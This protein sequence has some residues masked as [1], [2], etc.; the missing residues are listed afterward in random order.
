MSSELKQGSSCD[1]S[2]LFLHDTPLI[3]TRSPGEF[4]KGSFPHA[5]NLPL[6]LDDERAKVG[7]CYKQ[8]GQ[9]AAI[10]L[11]HKLVCGEIKQQRVERWLEFA[12][13][14]PQGYLFCW[15]G[16]LRSQISLEW[17]QEAGV[18]YPRIP[19][20]Y[21]AL[22]RFLIDQ[23][24]AIIQKRPLIL[25]AGRTGSG[26]THVLNSLPTSIDLEGLAHHRGSS[27]GKRPYGQPSQISFENQLAIALLKKTAASS[28]PL[29][30]EDESS[31]IGRCSL[32][33][34]LYKQMKQSP[35]ILLEVPLEDRVNTIQ[36]DYIVELCNEYQQVHQEHG[37]DLF[38]SMLRNGL[39][40]IAKRLGGQSTQ[41]I[42]QILEEALA[43]QLSHGETAM[44]KIW[45][46]EL[47]VKYYDPSYDYQLSRNNQ[48]ILFKGNGQ[49]VKEWFTQG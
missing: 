10:S 27:F 41:F 19:G 44:H 2:Q 48:A 46:K 35:R 23:T 7:T 30:L 32:P 11:G 33:L 16:G 9:D 6:M 24:E 34:S 36:N 1:F 22:R 25:L 31:F 43:R 18:E 20:G 13:A 38:A 4:A 47:L 45:I 15:R 40:R 12:Q 8:R 17:L 29:L 5:L 14:H 26:K 21:K 39:Q 37:F 49:E 42:G 3:D 28:H